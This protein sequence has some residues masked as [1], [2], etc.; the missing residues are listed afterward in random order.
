MDGYPV[1]QGH[2]LIIPKR[3][4]IDYFGLSQAEINASNQ[5]I[6]DQKPKLQTSDPTDPLPKK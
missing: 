1:T 4:V 2:T 5:I 6:L 3:H